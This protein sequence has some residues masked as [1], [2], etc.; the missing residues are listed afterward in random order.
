M[1]DAKPTFQE[2][3]GCS[4]CKHSCHKDPQGQDPQV[5][6]KHFWCEALAKAVDAQDGK[7]CDRFAT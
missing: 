3:H 7:T 6:G 5:H 1:G 4:G 2:M